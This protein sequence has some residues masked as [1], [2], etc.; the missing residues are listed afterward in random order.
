MPRG[1]HENKHCLI[2]NY[3][4]QMSRIQVWSDLNTFPTLFF[5]SL[6]PL[7]TLFCLHFL[8]SLCKC[9]QQGFTVQR[10]KSR[11]ALCCTCKG[12]DKTNTISLALCPEFLQNDSSA[13]ATY[14]L[15]SRVTMIKIG[16]RFIPPTQLLLHMKLYK[17]VVNSVPTWTQGGRKS[18]LTV[19]WTNVLSSHFFLL[20]S[21]LLKQ[22]H[23]WSSDMLSSKKLQNPW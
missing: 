18:V 9:L 10:T 6:L 1:P 12:N 5:F 17:T 4:S 14:S 19:T 23:F 21:H 22:L 16:R 7:P 20:N 8:R 11:V 13:N 3:S 2:R 15:V